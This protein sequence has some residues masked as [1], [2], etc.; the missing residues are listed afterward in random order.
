MP[1]LT[2]ARVA[3]RKAPQLDEIRFGRFQAQIKLPRPLAQGLSDKR[4]IRTMLNTVQSRQ[5]LT[6]SRPL[7]SVQF[8][9]HSIEFP[10]KLSAQQGKTLE[11]HNL[12]LKPV[13]V[14][15]QLLKV[16]ASGFRS[17][18][19]VVPSTWNPRA[20]FEPELAGGSACP[21]ISHRR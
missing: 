4:R 17:S 10:T 5:N 7:C 6:E 20:K 16:H 11:E 9:D 18:C 2:L 19:S 13:E 1:S 8:L 12:A 14:T 3:L 21:P 15:Q